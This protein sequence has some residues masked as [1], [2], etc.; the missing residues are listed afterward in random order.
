MIMKKMTETFWFINIKTLFYKNVTF[1]K[2]LILSYI[3]GEK[4]PQ[5]EMYLSMTGV[6][7][8]SYYK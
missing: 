8:K 2:W 1:L 6:V 5:T 3:K 7:T 4:E